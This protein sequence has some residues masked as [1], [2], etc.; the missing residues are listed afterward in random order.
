MLLLSAKSTPPLH[1][2]PPP[3]H[4]TPPNPLLSFIS[5]PDINHTTWVR[6]SYRLRFLFANFGVGVFFLPYPRGNAI[7]WQGVG[8]GG[9]GG[10]GVEGVGGRGEGE[11]GFFSSLE[12]ETVSGLIPSRRSVNVGSDAIPQVFLRVSRAC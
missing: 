3:P 12:K 4:P 2:P 1:P 6:E 11:G 10:R 9:V 8:V 5:F 7:I